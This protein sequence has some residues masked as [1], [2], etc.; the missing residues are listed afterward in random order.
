M[1][2]SQCGLKDTSQQ[3]N[4]EILNFDKSESSKFEFGLTK[5]ELG[6]T[7]FGFDRSEILYIV[8]C[9]TGFAILTASGAFGLA[10]ILCV[11][12]S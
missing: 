6:P 11:T 4:Q 10:T 1:R 12:D 8:S 9:R 3:T 7:R 5:S 2:E